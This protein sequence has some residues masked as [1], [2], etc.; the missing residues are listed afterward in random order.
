MDD[1]K[2]YIYDEFTRDIEDKI[3]DVD[4]YINI[5]QLTDEQK[6]SLRDYFKLELKQIMI[7]EGF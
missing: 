5:S 4:N 2:S 7:N 3:Q 1:F 6:K